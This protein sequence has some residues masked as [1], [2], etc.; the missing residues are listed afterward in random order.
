MTVEPGSDSPDCAQ[1]E[2]RRVLARMGTARHRQGLYLSREYQVIEFKIKLTG[3]HAL[4]MHSSELANPLSQA[5]KRLAEVTAKRGKTD[6]DHEEIARREWAGGLY[7]D[8]IEGPYLPGMNIERALLDSARMSRLGKSIE[9]GVFITSDVNP[10]IYD[11]PRD[12]A[13]MLAK[14]TMFMHMSSAKVGRVRVMRTRPVFRSWS[15][16][17]TGTLDEEQMDF[18]ELVTVAQRAGRLVGVGDWRPRYGRFEAEVT[19]A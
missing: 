2:S 19:E 3:T 18:A 4:L 12:P 11:G 17:A 16:K 14:G 8:P 5:A 6:E 15:V 10:L 7:F 9:R 1:G 13:G